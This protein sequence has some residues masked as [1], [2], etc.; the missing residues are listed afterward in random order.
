VC[1]SVCVSCFVC[2]VFALPLISSVGLDHQ[3][4]RVKPVCPSLQHIIVMD[5]N[6]KPAERQQ[7]N[8]SGKVWPLVS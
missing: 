4:V 5:D 8:K 3:V 2:D 6:L 1:V 7:L